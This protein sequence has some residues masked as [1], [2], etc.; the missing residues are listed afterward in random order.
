MQIPV[1]PILNPIQGVADYAKNYWN[2]K[3]KSVYDPEYFSFL[4]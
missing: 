4:T 3:K 1:N 2:I